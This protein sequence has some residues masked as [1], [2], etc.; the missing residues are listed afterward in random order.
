MTTTTTPDHVG[1]RRPFLATRDEAALRRALRVNG[2]FSTASGAAVVAAGAW[3]GEQLGTAHTGWVRIAGVALVLYGLDLFLLA[4][5]RRASTGAPFVIGADVA[6][7]AGSVAV[8]VA[9]VVEPTGGRVLVA[10]VAVA[11]AVIAWLQWRA[12]R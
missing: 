6:W 12:W 11:V 9:G 8:L 2:L 1:T 4:R 3:V 5:A 7:V 10:G